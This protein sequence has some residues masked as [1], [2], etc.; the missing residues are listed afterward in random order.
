MV[1]LENSIPQ[2]SDA[3]LNGID[4][5]Y[6]QFNDVNFYIEDKDQENFYYEI[7]KKLFP[8][9]KLTKI[10]PLNGK[11]KVL[12]KAKRNKDDKKKIFLVDKDF[13]DILGKKVKQSN[14]F[15]LEQYSI[16]NY[17]VE[18]NSLKQYIIEEKPKTKHKEIS[19]SF[20]LIDC[21][22]SAAK[23][24]HDLTLM[25]LYVQRM[26]LKIKNTSIPPER[27]L[28]FGPI[29][30]LKNSEIE[31]YEN[32]IQTELNKIDRRLKVK[33]QIKKLKQHLKLSSCIDIIIHIPG[34]YLIKYV[35]C[36][37]EHSFS[38]ASR[39]I[40]SFI[41]RLARIN[42]FAN[43]EFFRVAVNKYLS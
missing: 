20:K 13:D 38:L 7:F 21:I 17:L 3:F 5:F 35:K 15:Y 36:K 14:L 33:S 26:G 42:D 2:K 8:E 10:F 6:V 1:T 39:N 28:Q 30:S 37:I 43:L 16:E 40:D 12:K 4:I 24:F 23:M 31:K 27:Y 34:K 41:F 22:N 18:E 25:H 9:I 29:I 19:K 32:E 11:D